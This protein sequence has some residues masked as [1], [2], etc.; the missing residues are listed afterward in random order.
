VSKLPVETVDFLI[1]AVPHD[2]SYRFYIRHKTL[3][4]E[5]VTAEVRGWFADEGISDIST[6]DIIISPVPGS[7]QRPKITPVP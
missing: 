5:K 7:L 3:P 4:P 6:L 2:N 1:R